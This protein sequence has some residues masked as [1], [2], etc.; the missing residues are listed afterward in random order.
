MALSRGIP[1]TITAS[2]GGI[3]FSFNR[4]HELDSQD[5]S[6][7][8]VREAFLAVI[9]PKRL[10]CPLPGS[11]AFSNL[12]LLPGGILRAL[13]RTSLNPTMTSSEGYAKIEDETS[14]GVFLPP[15]QITRAFLLQHTAA[16]GGDRLGARVMVRLLAS[17]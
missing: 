7:F 9:I 6:V 12:R 8:P 5:K 2:G 1:A 15:H 4:P 16:T 10:L 17:D 3:I 13:K 11:L 14:G